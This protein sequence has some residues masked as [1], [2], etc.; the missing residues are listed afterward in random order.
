MNLPSRSIRRNTLFSIATRIWI[1]TLTFSLPAILLAQRWDKT[2]E[3]PI[4]AATDYYYG[5]LTSV[6]SGPDGA[7]W[8]TDSEREVVGRMTTAGADTEYNIYYSSPQAITSGPDGALWIGLSGAIGRITTSGSFQSVPLP[9]GCCAQVQGITTGPDGALWFTE[10]GYCCG[11]SAIGNRIGRITTG[12]F[13]Q[14]SDQIPDSNPMGIAAGS[15][16]ALWFTEQQGN[17]IGRITTS[18]F[19]IE[20]PVS[21]CCN[22]QGITAGKPGELWFT[23]PNANQIG[24]ITT[25]GVVTEFP[26]PYANSN[27]WGITLGADGGIWFTEQNAARIGRVTY[28]PASGTDT[29]IEYPLLTGNS[30]PGAITAGSDGNLWFTDSSPTSTTGPYEGLGQAAACGLGLNLTY[31]NS[32]LGLSFTVGTS[33]ASTFGAYLIDG[34]GLKTL[35]SKSIAAVDPPSSFTKTS[36]GFPSVGSVSVFSMIGTPSNGLTCY[37]LESVNTGTA[38]STQTELEQARRTIVESGIV[39]SLPE[40]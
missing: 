36:T 35:W 38:A 11:S 37:D 21:G 13:I 27:P 30:G 5:S 22:L 9:S 7:L 14:E 24:R 4:P 39:E 17:R 6:T 18:G 2:A 34:S 40:P 15:D 16:G 31:A 3:F 8:Y 10:G 12:G 23:E 28:L 20:F 33:Q 32:D 19:I 25:G 26:L 1:I 29:I